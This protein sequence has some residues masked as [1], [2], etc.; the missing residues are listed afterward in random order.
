VTGSTIVWAT[1]RFGPDG[2]T[3][4]SQVTRR[5]LPGGRPKALYRSS[6]GVLGT[7]GVAGE[8]VVVEENV[9]RRSQAVVIRVLDVR[10][11]R[12]ISS[13]NVGNVL[14]LSHWPAWRGGWLAWAEFPSEEATYPLLYLRDPAGHVYREGVPAVDPCF[15]GPYLVY[16]AQREERAGGLFRRIH[17]IRALRLADLSVQT[18]A[19][20][21]TE[22]EGS[23]RAGIGMRSTERTLVA[24]L[25]APVTGGDAGDTRTVIR[26]YR[27]E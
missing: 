2:T 10:T 12:R 20:A 15:V 16:Q 9:N 8:R 26:V 19:A 3:G 23:W 21:D 22:A 27:F 7:V 5:D 11:G 18:L 24:Y 25:D 14:P 17:E 13:F 1:T 6:G 4:V